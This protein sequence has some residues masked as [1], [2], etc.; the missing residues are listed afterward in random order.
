MQCRLP[1][2]LPVVS[3]FLAINS[4]AASSNS[5]L[6]AF[7]NLPLSQLGKVE[8]T[9]ATGNSTPLDRAPATASVITAAE[10]EAMGAR[11][12]DEVLETVPGLHVSLSS[13][14]RLDSVYSI[15]GI[16][17]GFN[18][19]VLLLM[20][21]VPVQ[22]SV[23][24]GRPVMFRYPVTNIAR[25]EVIRGPGSAIYGADAYSGVIN[26]ITKDASMI[27]GTEFGVGYGSFNQ[28]EL[29]TLG[30]T[31]WQ[32]WAFTYN[33]TYQHSDGDSNRTVDVDFQSFLDSIPSFNS[34]AS[35]APGSLSTRYEI[36]NT[37]LSANSKHWSINLWSW[38]SNDSGVG[39]GAAQALDH[40]G[41]DDSDL[42]LID[43]TYKTVD[44]FD[45]WDF[46]IRLSYQ[47]Y[48]TEAQFNLVPEG[49][50]IPI[51]S[52]GNLDFMNGVLVSFPDGFIG[53]PGGVTQDSQIDFVS[54]YTGLENHRFRFAQGLRHQSLDSRET[55]NFGPGVIDGSQSVVDGGLTDVSDSSFVFVKDTSRRTEYLSI[56]DE[57]HFASDWDFTAGVRFDNYSDFGVTT[58]PR[59][60]LIW[61]AHEKITTKFLFGRAFRAPSFAEQ[62]NAN[63][64]IVLGNENLDPEVIH[65]HEFA[66][67][68]EASPTLHSNLSIF[69]YKAKG[70]IEYIPDA[71]AAGNRAQNA[72]DQNGKGF[73]W[74]VNWDVFANLRIRSSYS[75][76]DARDDVTDNKIA[77]APG[78]QISLNSH[79]DV[80][81][82]WSLNA[83]LNRVENR[84]RLDRDL[85]DDIDDYTLL[86]LTLRYKPSKSG[87][88][89]TFTVRNAA[90]EDAREP[91]G[92]D[93]ANLGIMTDDYPLE[94]R[95]IWADIHYQ[96]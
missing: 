44:K 54:I 52:D 35:L 14:S 71:L 70:M 73:E 85:R 20:N 21:G 55:K 46:Q 36:L 75:W 29:W 77:D 61:A 58:N 95:S 40:R 37:H 68:F 16:H 27:D 74:E 66:L 62:F 80:S 24:G 41:G 31:E 49:T 57:W 19:H 84:S 83:I 39:A 89:V 48:N 78:Q 15:R 18:P 60:A 53:N 86:D 4:F 26:V 33:L 1:V 32:D 64:P 90:D 88:G 96:F 65:T 81:E 17:T 45:H 25:V 11:N 51:G 67:S 2:L 9:T 38:N 50:V 56:Q 10:I 82:N 5:T 92:A 30:K 7:Y 42:F 34:S 79:W 47:Y 3:C 93:N 6:D 91:S 87:F 43:T 22:F 8:I 13:L 94:G 76:I 72:R 12:L 23:Q 28:A 63:N 69:Y 59:V